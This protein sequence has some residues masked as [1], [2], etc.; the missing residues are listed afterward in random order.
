[1]V[2]HDKK[3][4]RDMMIAPDTDLHLVL[5][6][7]LLERCRPEIARAFQKLVSHTDRILVAR[8]DKLGGWFR[9][10]RDNTAAHVAFREFA[11]SLNLNTGEYEGGHLVFPE[12]NDHFHRP[13]AGAGVI[14]STSVLHE[15]TP[16]TSGSRYVLLTFFHSD[17]AEARR[18]AYLAEVGEGEDP[19][20][21]YQ[22]VVARG[23]TAQ[24]S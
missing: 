2:D 17:A 11:L 4:R 18:L 10:H 22:N 14:F 7:L 19:V 9:R 3:H 15:A 13:Q 24:V 12:Y 21:D 1:V 5:H 16:V 20:G 6:D 23:G 8:Y